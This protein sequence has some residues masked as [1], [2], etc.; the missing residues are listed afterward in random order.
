MHVLGYLRHRNTSRAH[1]LIGGAERHVG[2]MQW[3]GHCSRIRATERACKVG[4]MH[5]RVSLG[6][7]DSGEVE[8]HVGALRDEW[9]R[10]HQMRSPHQHYYACVGVRKYKNHRLFHTYGD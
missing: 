1:G 4:V 8:T 5:G 10:T 7:A 6:D 3:D 2:A 9:E